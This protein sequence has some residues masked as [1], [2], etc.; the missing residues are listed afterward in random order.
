MTEEWRDIPSWPG[1]QASSLGRIKRIIP[2]GNNH[3]PRILK[4]CSFN[5]GYRMVQTTRNGKKI[6]VGVHVL[7]CEAFHGPR[8]PD[9]PIVRHLDNSKDNNRPE[10][11]RWGTYLENAADR[12][13]HLTERFG[14]QIQTA[15]LVDEDVV[16][17]FRLSARGMKGH[18]IAPLFGLNRNTVNK[19]LNRSA[20]SHVEISADTLAASSLRYL[21]RGGAN[22][23][24]DEGR[25]RH[26]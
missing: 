18:E 21:G 26:A 23:L 2:R 8:R 1:Y 13:I 4:G 10:N 7:V 24:T 5:G 12:K 6:G 11:L 20:W 17:I 14:A 15:K 3:F 16:A 9:A 19:I 25:L 22:G